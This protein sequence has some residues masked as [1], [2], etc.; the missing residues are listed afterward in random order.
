MTDTIHI[1]A[2]LATGAIHVGTIQGNGGRIGSASLHAGYALACKSALETLDLCKRLLETHPDRALPVYEPR[3][4]HVAMYP[5]DCAR[6][7]G[8][9]IAIPLAGTSFAIAEYDETRSS[10]L[11]RGFDAGNFANAY[12]STD[13]GEAIESDEEEHED[14]PDHPGH[15]SHFDHAAY[16]DAFVLGFF[17]SYEDHE[18]DGES[19][20][21]VIE[22][23]GNVGQVMLDMG[24]A[25]NLGSDEDEDEDSETN[26]AEVTS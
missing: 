22:A 2:T 14:E 13:L 21:R 8:I 3:S 1:K 26:G 9:A 5:N 18:I 24:I 16:L 17:G 6:S 23:R 10:V 4:G 12:E 20:E 25:V 7:Q 15:A 11:H 19:I